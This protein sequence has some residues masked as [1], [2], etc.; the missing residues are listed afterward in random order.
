VRLLWGSTA[1]WGHGELTKGLKAAA[2]RSG[3]PV[4][5]AQWCGVD[6]EST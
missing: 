6:D 1:S 4:V 5:A 3:R 2:W